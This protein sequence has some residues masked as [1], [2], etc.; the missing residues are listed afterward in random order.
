MIWESS[1]NIPSPKKKAGIRHSADASVT[2]NE[3]YP[4]KNKKQD[5]QGV[6]GRDYEE[7]W[8]GE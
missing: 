7:E 6:G 3:P 5:L 8:S 4:Y 2:G 1:T